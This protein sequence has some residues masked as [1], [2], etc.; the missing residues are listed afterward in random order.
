[1][2]HLKWACAK[3]GLSF[4]AVMN[5]LPPRQGGSDLHMSSIIEQQRI[6]LLLL[7]IYELS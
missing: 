6:A 1:V 4:T 2:A 5:H 7:T 3:S